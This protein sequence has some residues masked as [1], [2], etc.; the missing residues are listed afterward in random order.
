M[1]VCVW[2]V[3]GRGVRLVNWLSCLNAFIAL[4]LATTEAV[5][6]F[7]KLRLISRCSL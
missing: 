1:S 6:V 5:R 4:A 2:R 3:V 7:A